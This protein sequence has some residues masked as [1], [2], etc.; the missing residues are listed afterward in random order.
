L[1]PIAA[2][3]VNYLES[4]HRFKEADHLY[5]IYKK[6]KNTG[7][8]QP[9]RILDSFFASSCGYGLRSSRLIPISVATICLF[10]LVFY[11]IGDVTFSGKPRSII[12]ATLY[13]IET[14]VPTSTAKAVGFETWSFGLKVGRY[15]SLAAWFERLIGLAAVPILIYGLARWAKQRF[16]A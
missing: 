6:R 16:F 12:A 8:K 7:M 5:L 11:L 3:S 14:F 9:Y 1:G 13:S 10:T 15:S 2:K 4:R